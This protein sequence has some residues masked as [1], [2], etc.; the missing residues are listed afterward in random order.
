MISITVVGD[1][2]VYILGLIKVFAVVVW[3]NVLARLFDTTKTDR[4]IKMCCHDRDFVSIVFQLAREEKK[5]KLNKKRQQEHRNKN[6]K[7]NN[8]DTDKGQRK[9]VQLLN[10]T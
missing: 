3:W 10:E 6:N 2:L 5:S 1:W 7:N 9:K 4:T 8:N